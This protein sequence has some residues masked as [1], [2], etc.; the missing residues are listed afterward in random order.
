MLNAETKTIIKIFTK[1]EVARVLFF[2]NTICVQR[3]RSALHKPMEV[4]MVDKRKHPT[5]ERYLQEYWT[6]Y[7]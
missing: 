2:Q 4:I 7:L 6:N 5:F 3:T 1:Q